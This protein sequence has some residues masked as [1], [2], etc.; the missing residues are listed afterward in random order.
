MKLKILAISSV[1]AAALIGCGGSSSSSSDDKET[2]KTG[3]F[4]DA[5]VA[6]ISYE[7]TSGLSGATDTSGHFSYKDGDYVSFKLGN[8]KLGTTKADE[9]ITPLHITS[10]D[11]KK[12]AYIAYILQNLDT[13]G[14][15]KNGVIKLPD[16]EK[17]KTLL[18]SIN[19]DDEKNITDTISNLKSKLSDYTFADVNIN[20]ANK[21]MV[22]YLKDKGIMSVATGFTKK[23]LVGKTFYVVHTY[24]GDD[25]LEKYGYVVDMTFGFDEKMN[26][27]LEATYVGDEREGSADYSIDENGVLNIDSDGGT[28]KITNI[29]GDVIETYHTSAKEPES[30]EIRYF[31]STKKE[32]ENLALLLNIKEHNNFEPLKATEL[33]TLYVIGSNDDKTKWGTIELNLNGYDKKFEGVD[34]IGDKPVNLKGTYKIEDGKLVLT[35]EGDPYGDGEENPTDE[36]QIDKVENNYIK[37]KADADDTTENYIFLDKEIAQQFLN[38]KNK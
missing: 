1:L 26:Y 35:F 23:G 28:Y 14:D 12:A 9:T 21:T 20:E 11:T 8:V 6:G 15:N 13:D 34:N 29:F 31:V 30:N 25:E 37:L 10:S 38:I 18:S 32:A 24:K 16:N 4:V 5:P 3:T 27:H 36:W 33:L 22:D 19:L 7:T 2:T 17:L